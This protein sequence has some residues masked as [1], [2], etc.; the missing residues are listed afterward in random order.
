MLGGVTLRQNF[1]EIAEGSRLLLNLTNGNKTLE[2]GATIT[3]HIK[4]NIAMITLDTSNGQV[5]KFDGIT[6]NV[7]YTNQD[8]IPYIWLNS[9]IVYY[10]GQY[11][12]QVKAEGGFRHNRRNCFR[13]GVSQ[14]AILRFDGKSEE[15][16]VRD[17]SLTGFSITDRKKDLGLEQGTHVS[18]RYE[19]IGHELNLE[20]NLI[21]IEET[22]DFIIYGF[23]ITRSSRDLSSYVNIKQR[24]KRS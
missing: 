9:T 18:L 20:G 19:D 3:K 16:M 8:G 4:N 13:V 22:P 12:L 14:H 24:Q 6:I 5:L 1:S 7:T 23:V 2:M 15:V 10:Q 17:I 21:R 11:V